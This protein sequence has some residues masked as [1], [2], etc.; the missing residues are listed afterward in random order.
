VNTLT[1]RA[2]Q[3]Q[4]SCGCMLTFHRAAPPAEWADLPNRDFYLSLGYLSNLL[5]YLRGTGWEVVTIE[6]MLGRLERGEP[7]ERLVNFSVDDCYKDTWEH[8]VPLFR[9]HGVPVTL[10]VTTGIPD[11]TLELFWAGLESVLSSRQSVMFEGETMPVPTSVAKREAFRRISAVWDRGN[12][13]GEYLEFCW[14]NGADPVRLRKDHAIT[15]EMLESFRSDSLVEIGAHSVSHPRTGSLTAED[16]RRELEESGARL[17]SRLGVPCRHFAFPYGRSGDCGPRDFDLAQKAGF[18]SASTTRKGLLSSGQDVFS[19]PRNTV[20][21]A[22][23]SIAYANAL[24]SGLA[25]FG[26]RVL[27]RV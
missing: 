10:F 7:G 9:K 15:W 13:K 2:A 21:G 23:Q 11:G 20:N 16:A 24:L 26:A 3:W 1:A 12:I 8:A 25:G 6:E 18:A 5:T 4:K 27:G 19:L 17:R 14:V 22:Y